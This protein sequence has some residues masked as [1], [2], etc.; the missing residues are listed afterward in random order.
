MKGKNK[1]TAPLENFDSVSIEETTILMRHY[2]E[3]EE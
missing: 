3:Y 1:D 2:G